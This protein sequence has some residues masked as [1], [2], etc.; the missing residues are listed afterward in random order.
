MY[1]IDSLIFYIW[2][3]IKIVFCNGY[4]S[5]KWFICLDGLVFIFIYSYLKFSDGIVEVLF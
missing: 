5:I 3:L 2:E 4:Y 1:V